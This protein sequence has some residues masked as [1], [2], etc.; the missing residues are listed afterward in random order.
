MLVNTL[1]ICGDGY[2]YILIGVLFFFQVF[3]INYLVSQLMFLQIFHLLTA[4]SHTEVSFLKRDPNGNIVF[5][6]P[7]GVIPAITIF[8]NFIFIIIIVNLMLLKQTCLPNYSSKR[9]GRVTFKIFENWFSLQDC[10]K[11]YQNQG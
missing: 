9:M 5:Q 7:F 10:E 3:L 11:R 4:L 1:L 2:I 6:L 8:T